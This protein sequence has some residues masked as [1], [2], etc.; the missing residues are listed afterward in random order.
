[1]KKIIAMVLGAVGAL[2]V[3]MSSASA[4]VYTYVGSWSVY[5]TRAP[6]WYGSPPNGPLAYTGQEAAALLFG[7]TAAN[8]AISTV[9]N[10]VANINHQSWYD[11]IGFGGNTFAENYSSK[12][13]GQYYGPTSG[14]GGT[15]NTAAASA[16][17]RD[18]FVSQTNYAFAVSGVPEP[19][20]W[21]LM[22]IGF[23]GLGF[24]GYRRKQASIAA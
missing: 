21:A 4:A 19:S 18:N 15:V 12:Y 11:V 17:V 5:D 16:F 14:Y 23:A 6:V 20:T 7:G 2:T 9:D 1:M 10:I 24:V 8:Y 22:I 13:L 3:S